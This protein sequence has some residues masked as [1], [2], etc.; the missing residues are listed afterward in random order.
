MGW[1]VNWTEKGWTN[2]WTTSFDPSDENINPNSWQDEI[3]NL[4]TDEL[5]N[6]I[7]FTS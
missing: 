2:T 6:P 3:G 5:G 7:I 1:L 4:M